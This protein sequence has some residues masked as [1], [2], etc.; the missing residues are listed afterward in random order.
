MHRLA[1]A[2][3][4]TIL[5]VGLV[6]GTPAP[7]RSSEGDAAEAPSFDAALEGTEALSGLLTLHLDRKKG[8]V[9]LELPAATGDSGEIAR[10]LYVEGLVSGLGSNPV[11][12]DRGQLGDSR[13][14]R[15]RRLGGRLLVEQENTRFR[16]LT[17]REDERR[18]ARESFATSVLWAGKILAE[19]EDG[20][21]LVEITPFVVRDA[22]DIPARLEA[23]E[24]GSFSLD[25]ERSVLQA[26]GCK[27]FPD[28]VELEA[29]L[30]YAGSKPGSEVRGTAPEPSAITLVQH[31]SL[32]RLPDP[33]YRPRELD[34]HMASFGIA[35]Q[36]Y[37]APLDAPLARRWISRHRLDKVDPGAE[38]SAV[39][40][41]IVYY[42][43]RGAP[44]EVRQA[45]IDGASWW[46]EAFAAAGYE[47]AYRV[48]L[49]PEGADPLDVRYNVIQWVHR[50]TRG[51]SYGGGVIDPRTGEIIKGHVILGSL[52][53]RQDRR[54]FE[55]LLGADGSGSGSPDDPVRLSL[56][57]I[58]QLAAHEV[59][60]TLGFAHNFAAS[61]YGRE[62]VMD[63][64]APWVLPADD[65][66]LDVSSAYD[67]GMGEWD[68]LSVRWAYGEPAAGTP[69][70]EYLQALVQEGL[71]RGLVYLTDEDARPA[72]AADP[73]ASLWDNGSDPVD[74]LELDLEVRRRALA[75]FG[76]GNVP[77]GEALS[78]LDEVLATVYFRHRYQ[79]EAA[80]KVV[81][82]LRYAYAVRGDGQGPVEM[83]DAG[84]QRR[85]V[86]VI[87]SLL[88]PEELDIP[89]DVLGWLH[90]RP[91]GRSTN[92]EQIRGGAKPAFDALGAART[93][94]DLAVGGLLVPERALR[95]VDQHRRD[96]ALPGLGE[97]VDSLVDKAFPEEPPASPRHVELRRAVQEVVTARLIG[98]AED[99]Q[100]APIVRALAS[101]GARRVLA[102][103]SGGDGVFGS[104][105][106]EAAHRAWLA[107]EIERHLERQREAAPP[108]GAPETPP[109]QPIGGFG[110]GAWLDLGSCSMDPGL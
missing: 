75:A 108:T 86:R 90:P 73:R 109:G 70:Q 101:D 31:H 80:Q 106:G 93:A 52:R 97:V 40:E 94:A 7:V 5:L 71:D 81:G 54:I 62:S 103:A 3:L 55:G 102:E 82:G 33:G 64:P 65:G 85:A 25:P 44:E 41:P 110:G 92:R 19:A 43:D 39:V 76:P 88:E 91:F 78:M 28:N 104:D 11:G 60:H 32:V 84:R 107:R 22:H 79:L 17:D 20:R 63:Y 61:V 50:E 42:V 89:E 4:A 45:L 14:V 87:L 15:L 37:A 27:V 100:A 29:V 12:L 72:G 10:L 18:A 24:Q 6:V 95:L 96:P 98:L 21:A 23:A 36:D 9:L 1:I 49:L 99:P 74:Q 30:T 2:H 13:L 51:W 16:A 47:D 83:L 67:V 48:E 56:A 77:A 8:R 105:R 66:G 57:R 58:R 69:E 59:G 35:F 34:P 26:E 38:H 68:L 46:A 53:V